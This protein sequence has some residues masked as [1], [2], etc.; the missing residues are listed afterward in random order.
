M[1]FRKTTVENDGNIEVFWFAQVLDHV[2]TSSCTLMAILRDPELDL[3]LNF[4]DLCRRALIFV[5]FFVN[6]V[7]GASLPELD[8]AQESL[9]PPELDRRAQGPWARADVV[10]NS[11]RPMNNLVCMR[12]I[13][14]WFRGIDFV[15]AH[16]LRDSRNSCH[17]MP[18]HAMPCHA[19]PRI[20]LPPVK[21][22][23]S[24]AQIF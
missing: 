4:D 11:R 21:T 16:F 22:P 9:S 14:P 23:R 18:C 24:A 20:A 7:T 3:K 10:R 5:Q 13:P 2:I 8:R 17:A 6:F 19:I 15:L 1:Q 12:Q